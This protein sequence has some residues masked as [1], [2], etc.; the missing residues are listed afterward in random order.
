MASVICI[1]CS[2]VDGVKKMMMK[3]ENASQATEK[4]NSVYGYS[5]KHNF[6]LVDF[7]PEI[8]K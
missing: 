2:T 4:V 5:I 7:V 8:L 3:G 6:C 1:S